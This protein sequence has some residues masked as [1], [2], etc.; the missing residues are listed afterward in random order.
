MDKEKFISA[1]ENGYVIT[2]K[3]GDLTIT[4]DCWSFTAPFTFRYLKYGQL[5]YRNYNNDVYSYPCNSV[6]ELWDLASAD[7]FS[8]SNG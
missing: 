5:Y 4:T 2:V 8:G 7:S 1:I 3:D 6:E